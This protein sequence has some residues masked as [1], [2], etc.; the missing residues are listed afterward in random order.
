MLGTLNISSYN[1]HNIFVQHY[2]HFTYE[3][4]EAQSS[5]LFKIIELISSRIRIMNTSK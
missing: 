1:F 5:N 2:P 4:T 3:K